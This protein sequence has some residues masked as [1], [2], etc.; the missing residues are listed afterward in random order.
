MKLIDMKN[1]KLY[2]LIILVALFS[3]S[4]EAAER[5]ES[6]LLQFGLVADIQ[7]ADC[8]PVESR[9]Y[10]NSLSKLGESIEYFNREGVEFIVNLGDIVDRD[11]R[12]LDAVVS[13]LDRA[14]SRVYNTTGNHD[15]SGVT[16]N[17]EL[18][19]KLGM[20]HDYYSFE[21]EGWLFVMLNTN[22]IA[23]Y[24]NIEGSDKEEELTAVLESLKSEGAPQGEV[25]N[26]GVSREQLEW[27]DALLAEAEREGK[28]V[29]VFTH[30]PLYPLHD[31]VALNSADILNVMERYSVVKALFSGHV[32]SG[33]FALYKDIPLIIVEGMLETESANAFGIVKLYD[34]RIVIEG[35][36]RLTSRILPLSN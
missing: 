29:V 19:K 9:Y 27:F 31:A 17:R 2:C 34:D 22:E 1:I 23:T 21:S 16:D 7:Y 14:D 28:R 25:W 18:Y 33:G 24:S 13:H 35:R 20:P 30:H 4:T 5:G 3:I 10:R 12:D 32:H 36:G 11:F 15:Y 6:P 8:D 26:G